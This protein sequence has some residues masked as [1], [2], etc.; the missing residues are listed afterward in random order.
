[1]IVKPIFCK[2]QDYCSPLDATWCLPLKN[3]ANIVL[4]GAPGVNLAHKNVNAPQLN[5]IDR[6][7]ATLHMYD[8]PSANHTGYIK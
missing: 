7:K 3:R 5:Q 4:S 1:M 8:R 2:E 6:D